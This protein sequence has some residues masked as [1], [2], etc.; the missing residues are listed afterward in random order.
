MAGMPLGV[1]KMRLIMKNKVLHFIN[2][3]T[4]V[5]I[6]T[7]LLRLIIQW[8]KEEERSLLRSQ[9]APQDII[10]SHWEGRM[11]YVSSILVVLMI[12]QG[13]NNKLPQKIDY[14]MLDP[15]LCEKDEVLYYSPTGFIDKTGEKWLVILFNKNYSK[16]YIVGRLGSKDVEIKELNINDICIKQTKG[17]KLEKRDGIIIHNSP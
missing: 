15:L 13:Y 7:V 17:G 14:K 1:L 8:T 3:A 4:L 6:T 5:F 11:F 2:V 12:E 9:K 10:Y 16:K